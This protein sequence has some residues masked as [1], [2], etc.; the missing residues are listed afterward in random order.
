MK[1]SNGTLN[2]VSNAFTMN[3][4]LDPMVLEGSLRKIDLN[5]AFNH[6]KLIID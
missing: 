3:G 2:L 4:T 6:G 1:R 5:Y